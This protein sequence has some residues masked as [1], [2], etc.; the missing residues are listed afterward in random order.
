MKK[1]TRLISFLLTT[2]VVVSPL[3]LAYRY[4][5]ANGYRDRWGRTPG[6]DGHSDPDRNA[7]SRDP[8]RPTAAGRDPDRSNR[9]ANHLTGAD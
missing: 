9:D 7:G 3:F 6:Q 2:L 5:G 8:D 4:A 1:R